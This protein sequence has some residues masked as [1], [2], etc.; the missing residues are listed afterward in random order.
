MSETISPVGYIRRWERLSEALQRLIAAGVPESAA[1]SGLCAA[2][3]DG[4]VEIRLK[5]RKH[6]TRGTTARSRTFEGED[7]QIPVDL[8]PADLDFENSRPLK[9]WFM[10]R[11]KH[12]DLWGNWE[13][14]WIEVSGPDVTSVLLASEAGTLP[15]R[16][17]LPRPPRRPKTRPALEA[18]RRVIAELYPGGDPG[19]TTLPNS[20]L[21]K[22]V[23]A[24]MKA[25]G[26]PAVSD[27]TILR[28]AG[29][30]K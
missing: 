28:A 6:T 23:G 9:P 27:D 17:E 15:A 10:L 3:A 19:Q 22:A 1:K 20:L 5:L 18:A 30:R 21:C 26:L 29:R 8:Q 12:P 14:E 13:I 16:A 2:I 25:R 11:E 24:A 4:V 7:V